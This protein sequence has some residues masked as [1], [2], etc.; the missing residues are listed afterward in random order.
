MTELCK[1]LEAEFGFAFNAN[2][3][4]TPPNAKGFNVHYDTHDVFVLQIA[5]T[6]IWEIFES[7][8]ELPLPG[9]IHDA[10]GA[11]PGRVT[12]K[13][14]LEE[15]DL[16]YIPRGFFHHAIAGNDTSLHITLGAMVQTWCELLI[17][18]IS[19]LSLRDVA[20]RRGLPIGLEL[21]SFDPDGAERDFYRL[22]QRL[23]KS[24][25]FTAAIRSLRNEFVRTREAGLRDQLLQISKL[26]Q[27]SK[28]S[29]VVARRGAVCT[30]AYATD[31][32]NV[33][34]L[35]TSIEFPLEVADCLESLL[36]GVPMK[37]EDVSGNLDIAGKIVL[38]RRLIEEGLLRTLS[39]CGDANTA[40]SVPVS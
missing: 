30:V 11:Q 13:F 29:M 25:D 26:H 14:T 4:L 18:A 36:S 8:I 34:Y 5:G 2:L 19:E 12:D 22:L 27:L 15:G 3:Y 9:Q 7:P 23:T 37:I 31:K 28:N 33:E 24:I 16:A 38:A 39:H 17:E 40:I 21:S 32:I 1:E 6:K 10:S 20:F 35:N